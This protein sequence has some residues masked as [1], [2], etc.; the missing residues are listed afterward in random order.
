MAKLSEIENSV[1]KL[2]ENEY[3]KFRAWFW[4]YENEKWD[5]KIEKDISAN[6]LSNIANE[7]IADYKKGNS[8]ML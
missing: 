5:E 2:S 6:K 4:N 3:E 7:A 8:K 1:T